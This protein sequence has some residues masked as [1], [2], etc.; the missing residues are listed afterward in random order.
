MIDC[1]RLL[2]SNNN[3]SNGSNHER[4]ELTATLPFTG[5]ILFRWHWQRGHS[6]LAVGQ[7]HW[8]T[9]RQ[10]PGNNL[11]LHKL[12]HAYLNDILKLHF[13]VLLQRTLIIRASLLSIVFTV[14]IFCSSFLEWP[15]L[16]QGT[17]GRSD[18]KPI[19]IGGRKWTRKRVRQVVNINTTEHSLGKL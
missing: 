4:D 15:L 18:T 13:S 16:Q 6:G 5:R 3:S 14:F 11:P 7:C 9:A 17:L 10:A 8:H 2:R 12:K 19:G 1:I